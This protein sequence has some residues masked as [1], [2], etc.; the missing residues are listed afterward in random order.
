MKWTKDQ[1][2]HCQTYLMAWGAGQRSRKTEDHIRNCPFCNDIVFGGS[3]EFPLSLEEAALQLRAENRRKAR[4]K[5][6]KR[7]GVAAAALFVVAGGIS[8][9]TRPSKSSAPND[10]RTSILQDETFLDAQFGNGGKARI[11]NL[12]ET[13]GD[14][15]HCRTLAWIRKRK[16]ASL[17]D[18]L[19][20]SLKRSNP[21]IRDRALSELM[22]I[23]RNALKPHLNIILEAQSRIKDPEIGVLVSR[24][25][26]QI[27]SS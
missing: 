20:E 16:H 14:E 15:L 25:A 7:A 11:A 9:V 12:M 27:E 23:D 5:F 8:Q 17:Y 3:E 13:G 2:Y 19:C 1:H 18:L 21:R 6:I 24:L 26:M 10:V 4:R 22:S